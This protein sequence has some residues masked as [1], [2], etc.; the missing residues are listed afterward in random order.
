VLH[1]FGYATPEQAKRI[2]RLGIS[3]S[4]NPYYLW[5]LGEKYA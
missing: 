5:A 2:G 1:H 3:V 4:A